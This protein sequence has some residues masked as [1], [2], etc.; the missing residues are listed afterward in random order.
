M[1]AIKFISISNIEK[2]KIEKN[3][4]ASIKNELSS[5]QYLLSLNSP[6]I[7]HNSTDTGATLLRRFD[8]SHYTTLEIAETSEGTNSTVDSNSFDTISTRSSSKCI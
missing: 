1:F 6:E 5:L 4:K 8:K 3:R 7:P 2:Q